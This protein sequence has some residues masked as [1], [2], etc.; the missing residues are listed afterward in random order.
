MAQD[1]YVTP[2]PKA[3]PFSKK[4]ILIA[5]GIII[6]LIVGVMLLGMGGNSTPQQ[7]QRFSLRLS[8]LQSFLQA[9]I[10]RTNLKDQSLLQITSELKLSLATSKNELS[11]LLVSAGLPPKFDK[12]IIASEADTLSATTLE[13]AALNAKFDRTYA[14]TLEQKIVSLRALTAETFKIVKGKKLKSALITLDDSL[15]VAKKKLD[16]LSF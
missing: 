14:E 1:Y 4:M 16:K 2:T 6:A 12:A 10:V 13:A 3:S 8:G 11:P 5:A 9:P 15:L 7:L